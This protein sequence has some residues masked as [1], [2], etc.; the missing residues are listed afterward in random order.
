MLWLINDFAIRTHSNKKE[1][2]KELNYTQALR[3]ASTP[4]EGFTL[5]PPRLLVQRP[6]CLH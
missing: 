1:M 6:A 5:W 4:K 3:Y 2:R